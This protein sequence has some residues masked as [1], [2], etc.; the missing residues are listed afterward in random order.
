MTEEKL[1]KAN[2]LFKE[3]IDCEYQINE[4]K[5]AQSET[6]S[7]RKAELKWYG[8]ESAIVIPSSLFKVVTKLILSEYTQKLTELKTE[9][10][11]L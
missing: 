10:E 11:N 8:S 5:H 7:S 4:L 9:L 2:K 6:F 3:I 1:N